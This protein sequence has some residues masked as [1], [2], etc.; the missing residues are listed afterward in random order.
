MSIVQM[1]REN[2]GI[3]QLERVRVG[4]VKSVAIRH[5]GVFPLGKLA[6]ETRCGQ[7]FGGFDRWGGMSFDCHAG[8]NDR[9]V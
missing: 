4:L 6:S 2:A 3:R 1:N 5:K 9:G 7:L 8:A